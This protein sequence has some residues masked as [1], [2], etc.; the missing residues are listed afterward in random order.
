MNEHW[1]KLCEASRKFPCEDRMPD[2]A[3]AFAVGRVAAAMVAFAADD[4]AGFRQDIATAR[5]ALLGQ[6]ARDVTTWERRGYDADDVLVMWQSVSG[7]SSPRPLTQLG[8]V[9]GQAMQ[10]YALTGHF[11]LESLVLMLAWVSKL[12]LPRS[13]AEATLDVA[14]AFEQLAAEKAQPP[15]AFEPNPDRHA[16]ASKPHPSTEAAGEAVA[17]FVAKMT[18]ARLEAQLSDIVMVAKL[19]VRAG[20]DMA[21]ERQMLSF[22]Y[23]GDRRNV[24]PM[25]LH[26]LRAR[27]KEELCEAEA[28]AAPVR[29]TER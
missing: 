1:E 18:E 5:S 4:L 10:G 22:V 28:T 17:A 13:F 11:S 20:A 26:A 23:Q 24:R 2:G 21:F 6:L 19:N 16:Q 8:I 14:E 12:D 15:A 7:I 9:A 29:E 27:E 3:Y 25:L